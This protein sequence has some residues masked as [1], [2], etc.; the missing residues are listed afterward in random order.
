MRHARLAWM[1]VAVALVLAGAGCSSASST[2]SSSSVVKGGVASFGFVSGD[3]PNSIFPY[4]S[5]AYSSVANL[6]DLQQPLYWFGGQNDQPTAD[7]GLSVAK[8]P[9]YSDGGK[10][11]VI[12]MKGWKWSDGETV[13]AAR[14]GAHW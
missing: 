1:A 11:V 4:D 14:S 6:D 9:V 2:P 5:P 8:A 7:Y 3:Q 12:N 13:D 10:T